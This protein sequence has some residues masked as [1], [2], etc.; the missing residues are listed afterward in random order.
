MPLA[1]AGGDNASMSSTFLRRALA[2]VGGAVL[3]VNALVITRTSCLDG[4]VTWHWFD[5][6]P[7]P[8]IC[9]DQ[10]LIVYLVLDQWLFVLAAGLLLVA[11]V[12]ARA[13]TRTQRP[14]R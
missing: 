6:G 11:F 12:I 5:V 13:R 4:S 3:A 14:D 10:P 2:L 8:A 7:I 9:D 1:A